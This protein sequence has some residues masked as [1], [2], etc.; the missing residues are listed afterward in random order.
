MSDTYR[1]ILIIR[2]LA[3]LRCVAMNNGEG[4]RNVALDLGNDGMGM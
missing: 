2:T 3:A 1:Q 4:V